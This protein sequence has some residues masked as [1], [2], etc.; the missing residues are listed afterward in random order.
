M[1][2]RADALGALIALIHGWKADGETAGLII[3]TLLYGHGAKYDFVGGACRLRLAG[4]T[5]TCTASA[6]GALNAWVRAAE[7]RIA[8]EIGA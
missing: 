3:G 1:S 7:R 5:A 6:E 8:R 4:V 2:A